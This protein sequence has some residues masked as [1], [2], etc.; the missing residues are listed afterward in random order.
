MLRNWV[1]SLERNE[2]VTIKRNR[3]VSIS[4]FSNI[5]SNV[6][7]RSI[8]PRMTQVMSLVKNQDITS[9]RGLRNVAV[10]I[11]TAPAKTILKGFEFNT[12][13]MLGS[14]IFKP[15]SLAPATGVITISNFVP[16]TDLNFPAGATNVSITGG[17]GIINFATGVSDFKLTN[18]VNLPINSTSTSMTL[19]PTAVPTGTG[20]KVYLLKIEFFQIINGVQY[21][22]KNG[23][24]N[25]LKVIEV[26]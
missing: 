22:L 19:T 1:V 8:V 18:P 20:T 3:V 10:G 23:A 2:V 5:T 12:Q 13:A 11:A 15:Y 17:F 26:A 21:S 7:D 24:Y 9:A 14:V 4:G 25:A 6:S 16:T